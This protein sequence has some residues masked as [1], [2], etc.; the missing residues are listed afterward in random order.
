MKN[1]QPKPTPPEPTPDVPV[2]VLV[3]VD[4]RSAG[5]VN[6]VVN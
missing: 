6:S 1:C 2:E 3:G 4:W 5:A